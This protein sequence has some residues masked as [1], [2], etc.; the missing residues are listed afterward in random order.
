[1]AALGERLISITKQICSCFFDSSEKKNLLYMEL[2]IRRGQFLVPK[3]QQPIHPA[4]YVL[5]PRYFNI[6]GSP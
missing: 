4:K 2:L 1:M 5:R 6:V 3:Q